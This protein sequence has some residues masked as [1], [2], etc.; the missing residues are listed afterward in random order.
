MPLRKRGSPGFPW[1]ALLFLAVSFLTVLAVR[2][3]LLPSPL[4]GTGGMDIAAADLL[5]SI[6]EY[7]GDP[8]VTV[9]DN[10]PYF[11]D[12]QLTVTAWE[13]YS[14][15]DALGRC[16][17]AEA[18]VGRELMPEGERGE[19]T[20]VRP[21][22]WKQV[23]YDAMDGDPLYNRCHLIAFHLTGEN[24]NVRN[25]I[26]GTRYMN[27]EGMLDFENMIGDYVRDTGNHVL[28]RVTPV[29]RGRELVA[30]GVQMEAYSV[31]DGGRAVCFNVFCY[32]V[33]PGVEIDYATGESRL[34]GK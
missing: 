22:G 33:Q 3:I 26:T 6:P 14:D 4:L 5:D 2:Y 19:I 15:L 32:N 12:D 10:L 1:Q 13:S 31:E 24:A 23:W 34:S 20:Q 7:C 17:P 25:L 29:F 28:Y 9:N 16:G 8:Y 30:R 18:C 21:S 11:T 27:F